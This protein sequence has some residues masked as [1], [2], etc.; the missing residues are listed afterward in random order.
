VELAA[1]RQFA[2]LGEQIMAVNEAICEAR[3]VTPAAVEPP[4]AKPIARSGLDL[5]GL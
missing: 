5:Y 4:A 3:P 2:A 1:Y